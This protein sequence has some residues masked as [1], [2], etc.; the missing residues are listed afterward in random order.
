MAMDT[1]TAEHLWTYIFSDIVRVVIVLHFIML[2]TP[3]IPRTQHSHFVQPLGRV[4]T[5]FLCGLLTYQDI[6]L[7]YQISIVSPEGCAITIMF[8]RRGGVLVIFSILIVFSFWSGPSLAV[9]VIIVA[10]AEVFTFPGRGSLAEIIAGQWPTADVAVEGDFSH[11]HCGVSRN[12][13][14]TD[15]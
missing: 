7:R 1:S 15:K 3:G 2:V 12:K 14:Q 4:R 11:Y 9:T 5:L 6:L 13:R 10:E 8:T